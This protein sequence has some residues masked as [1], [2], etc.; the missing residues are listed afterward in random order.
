VLLDASQAVG[1]L[2]VTLKA[3]PADLIAVGGHK[4]LLGPPGI[5]CLVV[6][7]LALELEPDAVGGTGHDSASVEPQ[8]VFPTLF[9]PGIANVPAIAELGRALKYLGTRERV[10]ET[11]TIAELRSD[12]LESLTAISGA[13]VYSSL[14][15]SVPVIAFNLDGTPPDRVSALM[16]Q[17]HG[18]QSRAGLHC[19]PLAHEALGTEPKGSVRV[20]FG[21][22]NTRDDVGRLLAIV[23]EIAKKGY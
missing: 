16:D 19:A 21:N 10:T 12:C 6:G 18:L 8:R 7:D 17:D 5:G 14:R 3:L 4:A 15:E 11:A 23:R 22:G 9:E 2:P 1:H 13:C 20:S